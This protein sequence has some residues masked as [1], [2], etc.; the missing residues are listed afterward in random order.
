LINNDEKLKKIYEEATRYA[1]FNSETNEIEGYFTLT[2]GK[3]EHQLSLYLVELL[4][5]LEKK[6]KEIELLRA[7]FEVVDW[8]LDSECLDMYLD[9]LANRFIAYHDWKKSNDK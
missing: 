9:D 8:I 7:V 5:V 6:D 3:R 4:A 1:Y 2:Q